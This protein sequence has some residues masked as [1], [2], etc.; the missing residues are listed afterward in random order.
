M[1]DIDMPAKTPKKKAKA[2]KILKKDMTPKQ[3]A[4]HEKKVQQRK[5]KREHERIVREREEHYKK[6]PNK[7]LYDHDGMKFTFRGGVPKLNPDE[8]IEEAIKYFQWNAEN[9]VEVSEQQN[10]QKWLDEDFEK[11]PPKPYKDPQT[12]EFIE[13]QKPIASPS[14]KKRALTLG[15]CILHMGICY[16]TWKN[17]RERDA[18][19][20]RGDEYR[21]AIAWVEESI[22]AMKI[23]DAHAGLMNPMIICRELG[24]QEANKV[25]T[26][27][28]EGNDIPLTSQV[29][30]PKDLVGAVS[31]LMKGGEDDSESES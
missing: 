20:Q 30:D 1:K 12:G 29:L 16:Q 17:Y 5:S 3:L 9:P 13:P 31:E 19:T 28:S 22:K 24:L 23:E 15:R 8:I 6:T 2:K 11:N 27:D 18:E 10:R 26:G 25:V 4:E 7:V 14:Y 21:A